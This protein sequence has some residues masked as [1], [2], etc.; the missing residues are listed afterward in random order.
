MEAEISAL[1]EVIVLNPASNICYIVGAMSLTP[2]LRPYPVPGDYVIAADRGFDSLMAYGVNPDLAVGDFDSLGHKPNH[3]NVIQLPA[4][5]DDT[6]MVYAIRKGLELG[7]RRF[8]LL[9]GV[10]GRLEHTLGNLQL[11]DWLARHGAQGFLAGEKTAATCIRDNMAVTF[12]SSM[13]GYL[14]V[15]CNSGTAEGVDLAGLKFPLENHTL[16][17]DFPLGVSNQFLGQEAC[18]RVE[19]GSLILVWEDRGDFYAKLPKLWA[20]T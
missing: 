9:G 19:R 5:K 4:E 13:A 15:F 20:H 16:S 11:L 12:P 18:V 3:P 2:G 10:G 14:S 8:V 6:D 17:G 7:Y 1:T